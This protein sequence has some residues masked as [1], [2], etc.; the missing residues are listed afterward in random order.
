M[1][2]LHLVSGQ[3]PSVFIIHIG[4]SFSYMVIKQAL[5]KQ[6]WNTSVKVLTSTCTNGVWMHWVWK[7]RVHAWE[8]ESFSSKE[9][10][11][12]DAKAQ[13]KEGATLQVYQECN[14]S[15]GVT[16]MWRVP[17]E[18]YWPTPKVTFLWL[19]GQRRMCIVSAL[20]LWPSHVPQRI[21][22]DRC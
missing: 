12:D 17:T 20:R 2:H 4:F 16:H 11:R 7:Q 5:W 18:V 15:T 9:G 6:G 21:T 8:K 22:G 19:L 3:V 13:D 14:L 1:S 10:N